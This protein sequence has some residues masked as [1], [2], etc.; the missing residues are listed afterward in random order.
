MRKFREML[1]V[2]ATAVSLAANSVSCAQEGDGRDYEIAAQDLKYALRDLARQ[3]G[4]ELV[5]SSKAVVGKKAE[6]LQGHYTAQ[7]ALEILL[8][9]SGLTAEISDGAI[10]IRGRSVPQSAAADVDAGR[11]EIIVTG[12]RLRGTP[13]ASP[14]ISLTQR[15]MINGGHASLRDAIRDIP[16]NF[17]GGQNPAVGLGI[18][19]GNGLNLGSGTGLNLRGIGGDATL[20][21]LNG[22]RLPYNLNNN[23][24][25]ISTIP[26]EAIER[27]E[28]V[29][30]GSSAL[31]G[32]DAVAGVAN[33]LL[34][35]SFEGARL[36]ARLGT[37][38]EGG[39]FEQQYSAIAGGNWSSGG[40]YA[41]YE[42]SR[43]EPITADQRSFL[44]GRQPGLTLN[45]FLKH[46]NVLLKAR[47]NIGDRLSLDIATIYDK[48]WGGR[49]Y[50]LNPAGDYQTSG[51]ISR[52]RSTSFVVLPS[53]T[54]D[55]GGDWEIRASGSYGLNRSRYGSDTYSAGAI[56]RQTLGCYCGQAH[57]L[58]LAADGPL[59]DLPAGAAK[60]ALGG[61]YRKN[62]LHA[63]RTLGSA[64][65]IRASQ[66][67]YY[68]FGE[69]GIPLIS[70][71]QEF[72]FLKSLTFNAAA[73]FE[74]YPGLDEVLTP[75]FGLIASPNDDVTLK[76]SWGKSFKAPT[77]YQQHNIP[78]AILFNPATL[79]GSG[80]AAG[81]TAL[82]LSG[83]NINLKP[84]K[85]TTWSATLDLHPTWVDGLKIEV[86]YFNI[87][88]R[89]RVVSPISFLAQSLSNLNYS[90]LVNLSP[91]IVDVTGAVSNAAQFLNATGASYLPQNVQ[92]I[93]NNS[94]T[95]AASQMIDGVDIFARYSFSAGVDTDVTLS[96]NG[97]Y[98]DSSQRLSSL[99]PEVPL[100]G[101]LFN[102]PH[103]RARSGA[104][105]EY[106]G[107]TAA[108]FVNYIGHA[109]DTRAVNNV[110]LGSVVTADLTSH[111][112]FDPDATGISGL[113]LSLAI[114][115]VF[116]AKPDL[117]ATSVGFETPYDSTNYSAIGRFISF[118]ISKKW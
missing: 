26:F 37:S 97:S 6:A 90:D 58:E 50:A 22:H 111:Y 9:G 71:A 40:I 39:G 3:S 28:I 94:S 64:Q 12:T 77:L 17:N 70:E 91:T 45:P 11:T 23:S 80:Y 16:Q 104:V 112:S 67:A 20:T 54:F 83:G 1:L 117:I 29:A 84:E 44:G 18:P 42:F 66:T 82:Y 48:R 74:S 51:Q 7:Q 4:L 31:Y 33:I 96:L 59:F 41:A 25:D 36:S 69:L 85:A 79:G 118:T 62:I 114:N 2:G 61:G 99:Q 52:D 86:S 78:I 110:R 103:F 65:D 55:A 88:Y 46:H 8:R 43:I 105:L 38:T 75:K 109:T 49:S 92:A 93:V 35:N 100:A 95:N 107:L 56:T 73:R 47:Q 30:D 98:L 63:Y 113:E 13:V 106:R 72:S 34:R 60:V 115:N 15:E 116:N 68:G 87:K 101:I 57:S 81:E 21:L 14:V 89:D 10:L 102:P 24:V 76:L 19:E 5:A 53:L 32:S 27:V 108:A